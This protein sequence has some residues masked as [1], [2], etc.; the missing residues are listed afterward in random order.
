MQSRARPGADKSRHAAVAGIVVAALG[1]VLEDRAVADGERG[2][3]IEVAAEAHD[4][5]TSQGF[6][7]QDHGAGTGVAVAT[8]GLVPVEDAAHDGA[9]TSEL[10]VKST[11][12]GTPD[13]AE[14]GRDGRGVVAADGLVLTEGGG[15]DIAR[16]LG[17][18]DGAAEAIIFERFREARTAVAT[19]AGKALVPIE[20]ASGDREVAIVVDAPPSALPV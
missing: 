14:V 4:D 16:R 19:A 12:L 10:I 13:R 1:G 7:D 8:Q 6:S 2:R 5:R 11:P 3:A 20:G 17:V 15:G 18:G 9:R